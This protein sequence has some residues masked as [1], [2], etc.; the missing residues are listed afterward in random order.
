[1]ST[2]TT[3]PAHGGLDGAIA[4]AEEYLSVVFGRVRS[5]WKEAAASIHPELQP[6]GYKILA[7]IV[8]LGETSA[9]ALAELLD[10]DKSVVSR[11]IRM[12]EEAGLVTSRTD[13]NDG[14]A[15][16]LSATPEAIARVR[17][18]RGTQQ[19]RLR[20]LLRSRPESEVRIFADI[21]KLIGEG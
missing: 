8:R 1:M 4:D 11:Q 9:G 6:V 14:R 13:A 3:T 21:L 5:A 2:M 7:T 19:G 12:L 18:A 15:R 10:T 17:A 16:V 20:D